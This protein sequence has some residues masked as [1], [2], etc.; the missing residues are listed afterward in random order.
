MDMAMETW[1]LFER[2]LVGRFDRVSRLDHEWE[3]NL[4][5]LTVLTS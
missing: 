4:C 5:E 3:F 2:R 1:S